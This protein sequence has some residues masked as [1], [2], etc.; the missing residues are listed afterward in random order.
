MLLTADVALQL[1]CGLAAKVLGVFCH[2]R[3]QLIIIH[4]DHSLR[5][6]LGDCSHF[7]GV[8]PDRLAVLIAAEDT[9]GNRR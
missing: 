6:F 8:G 1:R 3:L 4:L 9:G 2:G 5:L 7:G